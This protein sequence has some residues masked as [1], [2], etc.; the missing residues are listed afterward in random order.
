MPVLIDRYQVLA[1]LD[2]V[3]NFHFDPRAMAHLTPPPVIVQIH[4]TEPLAENS[5]TTFTLWFGPLPVK[6]RARHVRVSRE[7]GFT[8]LQEH[9]PFLRWEHTHAWRADG[10]DSTE[11]VEIIHYQHKSGIQGWFTR[12]LFAP[13]MLRLMFAYRRGVITRIC[14]KRRQT[15]QMPV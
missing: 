15:A 11:M 4:S 6:W 2:A 8:D 14:E 13:I 12:L 7:G 9:G 10:P 5:R 1:P 3:S